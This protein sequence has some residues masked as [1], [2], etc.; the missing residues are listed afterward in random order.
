MHNHL[1]DISEE[2]QDDFWPS[3]KIDDNLVGHDILQKLLKET[4][5][6]KQEQKQGQGIR[7]RSL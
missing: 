6:G 4:N 5:I 2:W 1:H 7:T 3:I